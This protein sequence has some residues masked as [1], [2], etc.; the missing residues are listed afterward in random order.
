[1]ALKSRRTR[2]E[3]L[4]AAV[5]QTRRLMA[6]DALEQAYTAQA[7]AG[8]IAIEL[9]SGKIVHQSPSF[10][11]LSSWLPM[12]ARGNIRVALES[13]DGDDFHSF[14][15][16]AAR[17]AGELFGETFLDRK[18]VVG[19]SITVRFFTR[20][21]GP[22]GLRNPEWLLMMRAVKLKLVGV[23]PQQ[24]ARESPAAGMRLPFFGQTRTPEAIGVFTA[25]LSGDMPSQWTVQAAHIR[26]LLDLGVA[27]GTYEMEIKNQK[28]LEQLAMF[29]NWEFSSG[30][31]A[32]GGDSVFSQVAAQLGYVTT[33][34]LDIAQRSAVW[35]TYKAL[36]VMFRWSMSLNDD[37][38]LSISASMIVR[39]IGG[40]SHF[41]SL[42]LVGGRAIFSSGGL[43][44]LCHFVA[45]PTQPL[46]GNLRTSW[47][48]IPSAKTAGEFAV[49][50]PLILAY[51]WG[52][53]KFHTFCKRLADDA[54]GKKL[55]PS[56]EEEVSHL[57]EKLK[58][59]PGLDDG[60]IKLCLG[61]SDGQPSR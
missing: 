29:F 47:V 34:A 40:F 2:A 56:V 25:D 7:G 21:P 32:G 57:F 48:R 28:P 44:A 42:D 16:S 3:L 18:K 54:W 36:T 51:T 37:D 24:L 61:D 31:G 39:L 60:N 43:D 23:Q 15:Q 27:T 17:D 9:T 19:R 13:R 46:D 41:I 35:L 10:Q 59:S 4:E 45:D 11:A 52:G 38:V 30:A 6:P 49:H 50:R 14:C 53:G 12:E 20:A 22:P 26:N 8:L 33:S 5:T 1:M 55:M 58:V